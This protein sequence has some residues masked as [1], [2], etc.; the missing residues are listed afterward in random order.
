MNIPPSIADMRRW[1]LW[2]LEERDGK[3]TKIPYQ[4]GGVRARSNDPS[5]WHA[6]NDV[7]RQS[8]FSGIGVMLG[9]GLVGI[10]LD[11]VIDN[12]VMMDDARVIIEEIDSYAE[13]SPSKTGV[14]IIAFG[15][16]PTGRRRKGYVEMY[17]SGRFFT[18]TGH[19][20]PGTPAD[21]VNRQD[22]LTALHRRIFPPPPPRPPQP[23]RPATAD[24]RVIL[25]LALRGWRFR[26]LWA[27]DLGEYGSHSEGDYALCCSLAYWTGG[28]EGRVDS[29]FRQSKLIRDKWNE[30]RGPT[31][32]GQI[33]VQRACAAQ[34]VYYDPNKRVS[35]YAF[36]RDLIRT[37]PPPPQSIDR[38][39]IDQVREQIYDEM[40]GYCLSSKNEILLVRASPG[41][42]KTT[43][44][45]RLAGALAAGGKRIKYNGP[46]HNF[47]GDILQAVERLGLGDLTTYE[48]LPRRDGTDAQTGTCIHTE[49]IN[50]W[51][52]KGY[53]G[54]N[55]C[56]GVC[57]WDYINTACVYHK[58]K[59]C[60]AQMVYAQHAHAVLGH[61]LE[62][63]FDIGDESPLGAF[64]HQW[65]I[66]HDDIV[67]PGLPVGGDV[68]RVY[69]A[70]R[71]VARGGEILHGP[72]LFREIE[73]AS[74][75]SGQAIVAR[76]SEIIMPSDAQPE[77]DKPYSLEDAAGAPVWHMPQSAPLLRRE[78]AAHVEGREWIHR[79]FAGDG[80]LLLLLRRVPADDLSHK[81]IW[82][83]ATG[84]ERIYRALFGRPV[85]VVDARPKLTA[86]VFQLFNRANGKA[87]LLSEETVVDESGKATTHLVPTA[88]AAQAHE[89][90]VRLCAQ[91]GYAKPAIITFKE[92]RPIFADIPG[93]R[94]GHFYA[95]R[96]TNEFEMCDACFVIGS[97]MPALAHIEALAAM[98]FFE[99][100]TA[101]NTKW[102][103]AP[104]RYN[105]VDDGGNGFEYPIGNFW[106]DDDLRAVADTLRSDEIEQA[107]Y[108]TRPITNPAPI[109]LLT[110]IP[111]DGL[112]P[113]K[114]VDMW[115]VLGRP[116]GVDDAKFR[117][118]LE[119]AD[120][121]APA[122]GSEVEVRHVAEAAGVDPRTA[123][124]YL[125]NSPDFTIETRDVAIRRR[126]RPPTVIR[127]VE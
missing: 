127:R 123:K 120:A 37:E 79:I 52:Q 1:V 95:S 122:E 100:D 31:T 67:H 125:G 59:N 75:L 76:L 89:V 124:K 18:F 9:G 84:N 90:V 83:D 103:S 22:R 12:G 78:A 58:Q 91:H 44:A 35:Q 7:A 54:I 111:I 72:D 14:H 55:F 126:G 53:K 46:R 24:D 104:V 105:Y 65:R 60:G 73:R 77:F 81:L 115:D 101:F 28:D 27:G 62:F 19:H 42:G 47:Y 10:D 88:K 43:T 121:L 74:G 117:A 5:T 112:P 16:L 92:L 36:D 32:Y 85:R 21:V 23:I 68:Y 109:W 93:A 94:L 30:R 63:D 110:N 57:G 17:D 86:P 39:A 118:V 69:D 87:S 41:T 45:V 13:L 102:S 119:A 38:P 48:W 33:T 97:P 11:H 116:D 66:R 34:T 80:H 20:L 25:D 71:T 49:A 3:M 26:K 56:S 64:V 40:A 15:R 8:G 107:A 106:G 114:L 113:A 51:M 99:R 29:L 61:P 98:I 50:A 70:I 108:R 96:G 6:Y 2:R 82:L 4:P